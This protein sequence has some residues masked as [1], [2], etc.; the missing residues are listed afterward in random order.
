M[1]RRTKIPRPTVFPKIRPTRRKGDSEP[2][3]SRRRADGTFPRNALL[4]VPKA[5]L[6]EMHDARRTALRALGH[7]NRSRT[8]LFVHAAGSVT[9][10][11]ISTRCS[12]STASAT[13]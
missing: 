1:I 7:R 10:V 11:E 12:P 5:V 2:S 13:A 8:L 6:G 9:D 3:D 4:A